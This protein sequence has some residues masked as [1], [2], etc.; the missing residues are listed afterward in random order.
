MLYVTLDT[1]GAVETVPNTPG[2][3]SNGR[4][5]LLGRRGCEFES[6]LSDFLQ[7][8]GPLWV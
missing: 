5:R 6:R 4:M 2:S 1:L 3:I 7:F 8:V